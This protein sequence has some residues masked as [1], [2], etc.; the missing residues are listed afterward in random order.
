MANICI[1]ALSRLKQHEPELEVS[2]ACIARLHLNHNHNKKI[3]ISIT[4][5]HFKT[6]RK[7]INQVYRK[8]KECKTRVENNQRTGKKSVKLKANPSKRSMKLTV[9]YLT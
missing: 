5:L 8:Q 7:G 4:F 2:F 6:P 9:L 1:P 3:N